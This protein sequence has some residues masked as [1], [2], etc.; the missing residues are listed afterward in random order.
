MGTYPVERLECL[1]DGIAEAFAFFGGVAQRCV[2]D[3]TSLVVKKVL[4]GRDR[5]VTEAF[6][7]FRGQYPFHA[8]FCKPAKGNEKGYPSDCT[9]CATSDAHFFLFSF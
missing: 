3:N 7:G 5:E 4:R 1:L 8:E 9:S 2:L 6:A